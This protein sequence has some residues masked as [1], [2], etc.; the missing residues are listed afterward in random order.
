MSMSGRE[1]GPV[2]DLDYYL[3]VPYLLALESVERPGGDWVRRA[4]YP[5]LPGR[6]AEAHSA[7]EAIDKLDEERQRIIHELWDR[8]AAIPV[9]RPPLAGTWQRLDQRRLGFARWLV[10]EGQVSDR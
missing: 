6:V 7:V 4:E 3:A 2:R 9:P 1:G 10:N 8:G 5:E